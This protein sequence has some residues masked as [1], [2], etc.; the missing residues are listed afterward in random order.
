MQLIE[1]RTALRRLKS[2]ETLV[3]HGMVLIGKSCLAAAALQDKQ[4][5]KTA[6]NGKV[7]WVNLAEIREEVEDKDKILQELHR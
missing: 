5:L 6:F 7:F 3:L 4:L 2:R 1:I